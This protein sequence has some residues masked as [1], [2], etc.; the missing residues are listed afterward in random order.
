[1][2]NLCFNQPRLLLFFLLFCGMTLSAERQKL[3]VRVA[4]DA[5]ELPRHLLFSQLSFP[6]KEGPFSLWFPEYPPGIHGPSYQLQNIAGLVIK[7]STGELLPWKRD[8]ASLYRFHLHIPSGVSEIQVELRYITNQ[9]TMTSKGVE[10]YG[11]RFLGVLNFNTC[12]LYPEGYTAQDLSYHLRVR[13]PEGWKWGSALPYEGQSGS[14]YSFAPVSLETLVDSPLI[15]GTYYRRIE[16]RIEEEVQP[17]NRTLA[18]PGFI[19]LVS[20]DPSVLGWNS[21][22]LGL[23]E[24]LFIQATRLFGSV[25]YPEYH[26]LVVCSD[27]LPATG[28]EHSRCSLNIVGKLDLIHRRNRMGWATY[29]L[30]HEF[31]H[32]WCGKYRRPLGMVRSNFHEAPHTKLLWV[33]EGLTQYLGEV[34]T[35]RAGFISFEEY[36]Q[37]LAWKIGNLQNQSGRQWRSLEDTAQTGY[38]LRGASTFWGNLRRNQDYYNEGVL[39]WMEVDG[40]LRQRSQHQR[41]FDDFCQI[42]FKSTP[43]SG[44]VSPYVLEDILEILQ[45]LAPY[46]WDGL[47]QGRIQEP[48]KEL[49]LD[50]L[51]LMG[52]KLDY[53]EDASDYIRFREYQRRYLSAEFSLGLTLGEDGTLKEILPGSVADQ[54]QLMTQ[55]K[56]IGINDKKFTPELFRKVLFESKKEKSLQLMIQ[57]GEVLFQKNLE[58]S[59]GERHPVLIRGASV[60]LLR[61]IFQLKKK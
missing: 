20:E 24:N 23:Y 4:V 36:T 58:Y 11:N 17:E 38:T 39:F 2:T 53:Q 42:F 46:D 16:Y 50:F 51:E 56:I 9:E 28:L 41:S 49:S 47:I 13:L 43:S 59:G 55:M 21:S 15:A 26:F 37:Q 7:T 44:Q 19:H 6:V 5:S 8:E 40:I 54:A 3:S 1:M 25:P 10:S 45:K 34:L 60:D 27:E 48:Q 30:P 35:V 22:L 32:A 33:Y 12:V 18:F 14:W 61:R 52:Y 29:L 31:V 57:E